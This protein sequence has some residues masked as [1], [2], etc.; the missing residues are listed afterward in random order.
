ML[1]EVLE[2]VVLNLFVLNLFVLK[3]FVLYQFVPNLAVLKLCD[4]MGV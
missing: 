4:N 3:L 1:A 2:L